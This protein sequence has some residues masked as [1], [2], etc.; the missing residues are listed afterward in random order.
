MTSSKR[1]YSPI[2]YQ[3][4]IIN[5]KTTYLFTCSQVVRLACLRQVSGLRFITYHYVNVLPSCVLSGGRTEVK[6]HGSGNI[7]FVVRYSLVYLI[8]Q[9]WKHFIRPSP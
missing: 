8:S 7:T 9:V 6:T 3:S 1:L 4:L 5:L 2:L